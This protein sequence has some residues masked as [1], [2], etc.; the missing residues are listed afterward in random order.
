MPIAGSGP[1]NGQ[2]DPSRARSSAASFPRT[3]FAPGPS[4]S[5]PDFAWPVCYE[6]TGNSARS[7]GLSEM[8]H[9]ERRM[10]MYTDPKAAYDCLVALLITRISQV[11]HYVTSEVVGN[12]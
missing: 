11:S 3:P 4:Q 8:H 1:R 7:L 6:G 5:P 9:I 2:E 10:Y 12:E